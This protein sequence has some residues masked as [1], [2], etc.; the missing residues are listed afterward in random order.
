METC[1]TEDDD[2]DTMVDEGV[3]V[4][5]WSDADRDG[6]A[7]TSATTLTQCP[8][9]PDGYTT[10]NPATGGAD[11]NDGDATIHPGAAEVC[12]GVDSNCTGD[13][14]A[15][16]ADGDGHT[17]TSFTGC[18]GGYPKDDCHDNEARVH[19]S[20]G[21]HGDPY[22][23]VGTCRCDDGTCTAAEPG[24]GCVRILCTGGGTSPPSWDFNCDGVQTR[25]PSSSSSCTCRI[26]FEPCP[27]G[28]TYSAGTACGSNVTYWSCGENVCGMCTGSSSRA[29]RLPCR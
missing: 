25:W 7:P 20:G 24:F 4:T 6:Y 9:C 8:P 26:G 18:T 11:C 22:C 10:T 27:S 1:D 2:C 14:S 28:Y 12:D 15:E 23:P 21:Y 17:R 3:T 5:C 19:G 29:E 13:G 16:D